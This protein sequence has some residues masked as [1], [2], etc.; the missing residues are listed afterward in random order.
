MSTGQLTLVEGLRDGAMLSAAG[1]AWFTGSE[2]VAGAVAVA[3][4]ASI[5][6]DWR[7]ERD[8]NP[9]ATET[10]E[11]RDESSFEE[12]QCPECGEWNFLYHVDEE[13]AFCS[14]CGGNVQKDADVNTRQR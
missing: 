8:D 10:R 11:K 12:W 5:Y 14:K 2:I 1:L 4:A 7:D 3:F 6:D 13:N 9:L